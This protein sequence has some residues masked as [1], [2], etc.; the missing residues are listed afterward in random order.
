MRS[1]VKVIVFLSSLFGFSQTQEMRWTE[2]KLTWDDFK[3]AYEPKSSGSAKTCYKINISPSNVQTDIHDHIINYEVVT[4][5]AVFLPEKSWSID[6][7]NDSN[8][9][10]HEQL[11]FDIAELF[12]RK[13]RKRFREL[14]DVKDARFSEYQN[15]YS[16]IW[17]ACR[18]FQKKYDSET[19]H[20]IKR[21]VNDE[22][23]EKVSKELDLL[24]AYK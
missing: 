2:N 18:K 9:L 3:G 22:W 21:K 10:R 15:A 20:G 4:V 11:H 23:S 5:E 13:I 6:K 8:L 1:F 16:T 17:K 7:K 19:I 14:K 12:A 24:Q